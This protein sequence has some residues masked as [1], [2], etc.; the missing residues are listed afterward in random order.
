MKLNFDIDPAINIYFEDD[1]GAVISA[2]IFPL[3]LEQD[4]IPNFGFCVVG[5]ENPAVLSKV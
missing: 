2:E 1:H 3:L 4:T 5:E